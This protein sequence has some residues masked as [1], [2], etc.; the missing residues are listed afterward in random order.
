MDCVKSK[1]V[2]N[3]SRRERFSTRQFPSRH[4]I[5]PRLRRG[6][7][8]R[9]RHSLKHDARTPVSL[10]R[11]RHERIERRV[12]LIAPFALEVTHDGFN[13]RYAR[14]VTRTR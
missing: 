11:F 8:V 7:N 1:A 10:A 4:L 12:R 14:P 3:A 13:L 9:G 2:L 5:F 6:G